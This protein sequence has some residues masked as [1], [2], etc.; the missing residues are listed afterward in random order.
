MSLCWE[1]PSCFPEQRDHFAFPPIKEETSGVSGSLPAFG[2]FAFLF[3][4][5]AVLVRVW[6]HLIVVL[7]C[8]FPAANDVSIFSPVHLPSVSSAWG[9]VCSHFTTLHRS[10]RVCLVLHFSVSSF[11]HSL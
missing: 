5:L 8:L 4:S 6:Q 7:M 1:K 9:H 11:E 2:V 10:A 3:I